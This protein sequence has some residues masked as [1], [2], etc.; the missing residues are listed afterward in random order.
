MSA[1]NVLTSFPSPCYLSH[2]LPDLHGFVL[3]PLHCRAGKLGGGLGYL[4]EGVILPTYL[5]FWEEH[6]FQSES[7]FWKGVG[8]AETGRLHD[9]CNTP[10]SL[11]AGGLEDC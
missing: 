10:A 2:R 11:R 6:M 9:K 7:V 8:R 3:H 1:P 4:T 5:H